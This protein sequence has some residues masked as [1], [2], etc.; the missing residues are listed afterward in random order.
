[1]LRRKHNQY[2]QP[3][4]ICEMRILLQTFELGDMHL[5]QNLCAYEAGDHQ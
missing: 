3:L 5:G 1:M 2:W 4:F